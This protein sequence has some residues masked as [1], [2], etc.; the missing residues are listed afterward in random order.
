M[1]VFKLIEPVIKFDLPKGRDFL[2]G[3]PSA[4]N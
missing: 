4:L 2:L 1:A 3:V